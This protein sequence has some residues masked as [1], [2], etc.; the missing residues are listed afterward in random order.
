MKASLLLKMGQ[1]LTMTPQLQQAIRLLQMS[2]LDLQAEIQDA[3]DSN[4]ML[5]REEEGETDSSAK[6][7]SDDGHEY[8]AN[9]QQN[10]PFIFRDSIGFTK[11][12]L[13]ADYLTVPLMLNFNSDPAHN[14][15]LSASIGVSA[16]Y[17]YSQRNKQ[18]SGERGKEKNKGDYDLERFKLSYV[19]EL[20][21]GPVRLYGS[22]SPKSFYQQGLNMKPYN[23]GIRFSNW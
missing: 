1:N 20:G 2:T 17:L 11:N 7:T 10:S 5:E 21:L 4:P 22:Y 15:G 14:K 3:L 19:A 8:T 13:A 9:T 23:I 6:D 12:K 16:G 18:R